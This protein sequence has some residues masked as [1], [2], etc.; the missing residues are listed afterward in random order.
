MGE[1]VPETTRNELEK[2]GGLEAFRANFQDRG[3]TSK[4]DRQKPGPIPSSTLQ[5]E[6]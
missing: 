6:D 5:R 1:K 2:V 4:Y 3:A